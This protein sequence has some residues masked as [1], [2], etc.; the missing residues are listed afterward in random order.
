MNIW[1]HIK[2]DSFT[3]LTDKH[4]ARYIE[5]LRW[6]GSQAECQHSSNWSDNSLHYTE[7]VQYG[8]DRAEKYN[9][10]HNL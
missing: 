7:V 4:V 1:Y 6:S 5:R 10:W 8:Y 2:S 3:C 9:H